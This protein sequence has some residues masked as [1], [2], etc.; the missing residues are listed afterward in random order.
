MAIRAVYL[1]QTSCLSLFFSVGEVVSVFCT[2]S[3]N[4]SGSLLGKSDGHLG[5]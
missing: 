2:L 4:L 3:E 1:P 5:S